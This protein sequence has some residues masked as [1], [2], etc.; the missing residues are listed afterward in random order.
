MNMAIHRKG[1][2][3][4]PHKPKSPPHPHHWSRGTRGNSVSLRRSPG[5]PGLPLP[6]CP[7]ARLGSRH[8]PGA[9]LRQQRAATRAESLGR[10]DRPDLRAESQPAGLPASAPGPLCCVTY[11]ARTRSSARSVTVPTPPYKHTNKKNQVP[12]QDVQKQKH[13]HSKRKRSLVLFFFFSFLQTGYCLCFPLRL[14][15]ARLALQVQS[16]AAFSWPAWARLHTAPGALGLTSSTG[17]DSEPG[18]WRLC[19]SGRWSLAPLWETLDPVTG[20]HGE[21]P[22]HPALTLLTR[23]SILF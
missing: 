4:N 15:E 1:W 11:G 13:R 19:G 5:T 20:A 10:P 3:P 21:D 8:P 16:A 9:G 6:S 22:A 14:W 2:V 17:P 23:Q 7:R 18:R 12:K